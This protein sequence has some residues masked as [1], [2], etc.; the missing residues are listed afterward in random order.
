VTVLLKSSRRPYRDVTIPDSSRLKAVNNVANTSSIQLIEKMTEALLGFVHRTLTSNLVAQDVKKRRLDICRKVMIAAPFRISPEIFHHFIH[1]E[2]EGLLS[3]VQFG[4][5]LR[6]VDHIDP[7]TTYHSRVMLSI[8]LPR[9]KEQ[10][11]DEDWF[12]LA[13]NHLGISR[14]DL[15]HYLT[16]GVSLLLANSIAFLRNI[17]ID[18]FWIPS[19]GD[20]ATLQETLRLVS[21]FDIEGTLPSLQ[22]DFCRQ[23]NDIIDIAGIVGYNRDRS[24]S[25]VILMNLR[26]AYLALHRNINPASTDISKTTHS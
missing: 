20:V 4:L 2:W 10:D 6:G 1:A 11:R 23:W 19:H 14:R 21:K 17:I 3:A 7:V 12:E 18:F 22:H 25:I 5:L 9:M 15:N 26:H 8:I 24:T 16:C 13:T